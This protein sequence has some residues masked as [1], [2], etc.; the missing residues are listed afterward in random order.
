M[1]PNA[2]QIH[3]RFFKEA[4]SRTDVVADF[5][6]AYLPEEFSSQ[7]DPETLIREQDSHID[8]ELSRHYVDLLFSV[9]LGSQ[10]ITIALLLEHKSY[11]EEYPHFQ[12]NQYLLNYWRDQLKAKKQ[13]RPI[14]PIVIYHGRSKWKQRPV[15]TYFAG[16]TDLLSRFVPD[17]DYYLI[18]L[19]SDPQNRFGLLKSSYAKLTAGLLKDIRQKQQLIQTIESLKQTIAQLVEDSLGEQFLRTALLY[20]SIGSGLTNIE[21]VAIFRN[22]STKTDNVIMSAY[23]TWVQEGIEKGI[24]KGMQQGVQQGVQQGTEQTSLQFIKGLLSLGMDAKAISDAF[25]MPLA[26]VEHYIKLIQ[27]K[28]K[29]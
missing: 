29:K 27:Q 13:L 11:P 26:T 25:T 15:R 28:K 14:V 4:F 21:V 22:I 19:T 6:Q 1:N 5:I 9:E 3:D 24:Q 8:D 23:E 20:V 10:P 2:K 18:N 12:L 17:F 16:I 7:L